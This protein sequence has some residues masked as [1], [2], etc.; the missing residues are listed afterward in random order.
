[1][2]NLQTVREMYEA[3]ARGDVAAVLSRLSKSVEWEY[4]PTSTNVPWLQRRYGRE[5]AAEFFA[6][7]AEMEFHKFS[8]KEF[9]EAPGV[10]V[11][12]VDV[13]LT[14]KATGTRI[15]EE[16]E[17]HVWR[18]NAAGE[19]TRFRHGVDTHLHYLA[20]NQS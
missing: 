19:V 4:G 7:H 20:Y 8:P 5:G 15:V 12:F 17:I 16:D 18:F 2:S 10:V 9:L 1:M 6:S 13:D 14:V 3:Y 11:V